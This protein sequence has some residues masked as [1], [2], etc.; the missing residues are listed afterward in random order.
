ML[1]DLSG[2]IG[3]LRQDNRFLFAILKEL[4]AD[5]TDQAKI[6]EAREYIKENEHIIT[7]HLDKLKLPKDSVLEN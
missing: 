1:S 3:A 6:N 7:A 4:S 5:S 2:H